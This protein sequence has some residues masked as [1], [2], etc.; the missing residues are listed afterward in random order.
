MYPIAKYDQTV[1]YVHDAYLKEGR[2]D[3][4]FDRTVYDSAE[5]MGTPIHLNFETW[6]ERLIVSQGALFWFWNDHTQASFA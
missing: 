6:F 4:L 5:H 2:N 3:Y 1:I